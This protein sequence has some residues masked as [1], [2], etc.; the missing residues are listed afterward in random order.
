VRERAGQVEDSDAPI[1][2]LWFRLSC[3]NNDTT[4][5]FGHIKPAP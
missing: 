1:D 2:V 4:D 3:R 5:S